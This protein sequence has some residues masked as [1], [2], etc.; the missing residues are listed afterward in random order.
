MGALRVLAVNKG[1]PPSLSM[2]SDTMVIVEIFP[3]A[4]NSSSSTN[5]EVRFVSLLSN[6]KNLNESDT[7]SPR[8]PEKVLYLFSPLPFVFNNVSLYVCSVKR[9]LS[10]SS[11]LFELSIRNMFTGSMDILEMKEITGD[12]SR[13][14]I[15]NKVSD[16]RVVKSILCFFVRLVLR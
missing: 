14:R 8:F 4:Y 9:Y 16:R 5:D 15:K 13:S 12:E 1:F 6:S 11:R 2:P 7:S 3:E 10:S